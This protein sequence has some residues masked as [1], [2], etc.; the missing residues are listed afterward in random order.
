MVRRAQMQKQM[1]ISST[2]ADKLLKKAKKMN[3]RMFEKGGANMAT[4]KKLSAEE[5]IEKIVRGRDWKKLTWADRK[6]IGKIIEQDKPNREMKETRRHLGALKKQRD[7]GVPQ[8][9]PRTFR[10]FSKQEKIKA[11]RREDRGAREKDGTIKLLKANKG[12]SINEDPLEGFEFTGKRDKKGNLQIKN[13]E[14]GET[15]ILLPGGDSVYP[16]GEKMAEGGSAGNYYWD[17]RRKRKKYEL[18]TPQPGGWGLDE[19]IMREFPMPKVKSMKG[20]SGR[21]NAAQRRRKEDAVKKMAKGGTAQ[22]NNAKKSRGA[23]AMIKG[24]TF[25][26]VY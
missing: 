12:G 3:N 1:D 22:S 21:S 8:P 15:S 7:A 19:S 20:D 26:G 5:Q 10:D 25:R 6:K 16:S 24:T 18:M 2:K 13:K 9:K 4:E 17:G 11:D 14:T 23:G